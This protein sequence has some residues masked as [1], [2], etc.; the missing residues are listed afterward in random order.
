MWGNDGVM[1]SAKTAEGI[2]MNFKVVSEIDKTCQVGSGNPYEPAIPKISG[3]VTVPSTANGYTVIGVGSYSFS[4]TGSKISSINLPNSITYIGNSAFNGLLSLTSI[5]LPNSITEIG[6]KAFQECEKLKA[7]ELPS[8]LTTIGKYAFLWCR[9]L[10]SIIIPNTVTN[11]GERAFAE[12]PSLTSV[13]L[14]SF[15]I[16]LNST[17]VI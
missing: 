4:Y 16:L 7:L 12:C 2:D 11:I 8:N 14:N 9:S 1:F 17:S 13:V 6:E 5:N 3:S 15:R 10:S